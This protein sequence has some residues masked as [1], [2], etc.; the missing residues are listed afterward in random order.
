MLIHIWKLKQVCSI[1]NPRRIERIYF[2]FPKIFPS[3][4]LSFYFGNKENILE[5]RRN[6]QHIKKEICVF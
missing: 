1:R 2:I 5:S 6:K 3:R 4:L